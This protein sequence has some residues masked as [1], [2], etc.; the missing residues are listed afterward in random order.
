MLAS[1]L[2][3]PLSYFESTPTGRLLNRYT[4][5][6]EIADLSLTEAMSTFMIALSWFVASIII[7]CTIL[8]WI[9]LGLVPIIVF[10]GFLL[11][12]YRR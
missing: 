9:L 2:K 6:M 3:A 5:D 10:Y 4:Y 11:L 12:H 8:P 7:L 1:T